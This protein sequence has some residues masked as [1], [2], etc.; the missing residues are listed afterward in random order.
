M[1]H[2]RFQGDIRGWVCSY[3]YQINAHSIR[4]QTGA[5]ILL[6][7]PVTI[8]AAGD[9]RLVFALQMNGVHLDRAVNPE[10]FDDVAIAADL[11][12][13]GFGQGHREVL[14]KNP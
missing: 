9:L 6:L 4:Q 11:R 2:R 12:E 3:I 14:Y 8:I 13:N 1:A 10:N 5:A 7:D